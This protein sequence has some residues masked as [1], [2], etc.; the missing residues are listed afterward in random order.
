LHLATRADTPVISS[1]DDLQGRPMV[2]Y[3]PDMIFDKELDYLGALGAGGVQLA[4]NSVAV[5]LQMLRHAGVGFVHDF[6]LP[7]APELHRVL[8]DTL[9]L[10]RSFY[11]VRHTS[12][13]HS[14]RLSRFATALI[15]GLHAEVKRLEATA[16]LTGTPVI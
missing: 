16:R 2:G 10:T 7:F 14:D 3:I 9:S 1:V 12:D 8:T 5:Q 15:A 13:R 4:S 11:L 6:V